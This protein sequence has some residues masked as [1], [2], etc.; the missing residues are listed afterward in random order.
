MSP[1]RR[2]QNE[3]TIQIFNAMNF[4]LKTIYEWQK[5]SSDIFAVH[6][7][8][9]KKEQNSDIPYSGDLWIRRG[10]LSERLLRNRQAER[11][12]R[13]VVD[14]G[15]SLFSWYRLMVI[16]TKAG[17][18]KAVLVC[19]VELLKQMENEDV[20]FESLPPW[21]DIL[22]GKLCKGCGFKQI[23]SLGEE[24]GIKKVPALFT[25]VERLKYW[26]TD[27]VNDS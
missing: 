16:Y 23:F 12:Y 4:D 3:D 6:A 2:V 20:F 13:Y 1:Q 7:A 11:A 17:N 8:Q 14:K 5:E 18:P 19:I 22:L 25:A 15:F 21:I 10:A 24:I 27:G 26:R 9:S